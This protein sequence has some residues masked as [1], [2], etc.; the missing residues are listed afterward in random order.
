MPFK[1]GEFLNV[2][3]YKLLSENALSS[4][5]M[6]RIW[7][8]NENKIHKNFAELSNTLYCIYFLFLIL[9]LFF[10]QQRIVLLEQK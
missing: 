4:N 2:G 9:I 6:L 8:Y 3:V 10:L 7:Y 5:L 1:K